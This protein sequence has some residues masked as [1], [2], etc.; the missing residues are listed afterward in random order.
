MLI[1]SLLLLTIG[2]TA[3]ACRAHSRLSEPPN[4]LNLSD[5]R[6]SIYIYVYKVFF[7]NTVIL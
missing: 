4:Y 7:E 3:K 1:D 6:E 5:N 2:V